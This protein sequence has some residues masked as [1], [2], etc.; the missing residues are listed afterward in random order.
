MNVKNDRCV[1]TTAIS[2]ED[3]KLLATMA[4]GFH[5]PSNS[6]IC[7]LVQYFLDR[8]I[9]WA[10]LSEQYSALPV[11]D[12]PDYPKK[13]QVRA[14]LDS[15]QYSAFAQKVEEWGSTTVIAI[16]RLIALYLAGKIERGDIWY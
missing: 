10:E 5:V 2:G 6:V 12:G 15:E 8:K 13:K 3:K 11:M 4:R 1:V 16:R 9:S 14:T 7:R